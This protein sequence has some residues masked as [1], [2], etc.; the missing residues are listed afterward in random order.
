[1]NTISVR[2][3]WMLVIAGF[4]IAS[5]VFLPI[6]SIQLDAPQYPEGLELKIHAS[7]LAGDVDVING[8]NHYI[9]MKTLH[10]DDFWEFTYLPYILGAFALFAWLVAFLRH[11]KAVL[12]L[13]IAFLIFGVL[14]LYDFWK[15]EYAYG[16]DLDPTAA[17]QVPGMAYQPPLIGFKQLLNFGAYSMPDAGGW[18]LLAGGLIIA[19]IFINESGWL[20]FLQKSSALSV[21]VTLVMAFVSCTPSG[22]E[23]IVIHKD[24]CMNCK[25][26]IS[27][28]HFGCEM[29]TSKGR[30]LKFDDLHCLKQYRKENPDIKISEYYVHDYPS[31]NVL[32]PARE[33]YYIKSDQYKSPM[34]GNTAAFKSQEA[35]REKAAQL[36]TGYVTWEEVLA[37]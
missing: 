35:V 5:S 24:S 19:F 9:G 27:E 2:S 26:K 28:G 23:P 17:I 1:M 3:V 10:A 18:A 34:A 20:R 33:A 4:C 30:Y 7:K 12:L 31:D 22:P 13:L 29:L 36:Q 8:L 6:W 16:H 25:M 11:R 32:V 21:C 14:S 15:W 37:N